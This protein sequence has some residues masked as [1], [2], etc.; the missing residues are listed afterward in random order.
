MVTLVFVDPDELASQNAKHEW[1]L[2]LQDEMLETRKRRFKYQLV[3]LT[4]IGAAFTAGALFFEKLQ[5]ALVFHIIPLLALSIDLFIAGESFT[6][7]RLSF[8]VAHSQKKDY[9]QSW[10]KFVQT[11][12]DRLARTANFLTTCLVSIGSV[13]LLFVATRRLKGAMSQVVVLAAVS[14]VVIVLDQVIF[15]RAEKKPFGEHQF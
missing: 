11:N 14:A 10:W 8:F 1:I 12:P 5:T 9:L 6:L 7:R 15:R 4:S 3:K 13:V 2:K